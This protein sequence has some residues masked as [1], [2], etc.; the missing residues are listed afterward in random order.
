MILKTKYKTTL[1]IGD[2]HAEPGQSNER[3][4]ALG[5][6]VAATQPDYMVQLGDFHTLDSISSHNTKKPLLR[7]GGRL[8]DDLEAGL[9]AY[10]KMMAPINKYNKT[11]T[12]HKKKKYNPVKHWLYGNHEDR[13]YRYIQEAPELLGL[14]NLSAMLDL[15]KDNWNV[16]QYREYAYI[17]E[18]GRTTGFTHIP[19]NKRL[20]QPISGEYVAR[21]AADTHAFDV[22]FGHTHRYGVHGA[23]V[24]G[25]DTNYGI[26]AGWFGDFI[27]GYVHGNEGNVDWWAGVVFLTHTDAG[28]IIQPVPMD[29]IKKDYL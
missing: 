13:V 9:D 26:N 3:F 23:T 15:A 22:V 6:L 10:T 4:E 2:P 21:R 17:N 19:M 16:H 20:N 28:L 25:A 7:E 12:K 27:P 24:V 1:V 8:V 5:N 11:L 14:V 18:A 29:A